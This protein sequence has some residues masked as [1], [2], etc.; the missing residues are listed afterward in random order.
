MQNRK[1]WCPGCG[2]RCSYFPLRPRANRLKCRYVI[3]VCKGPDCLPEIVD[4]IDQQA[5]YEAWKRQPA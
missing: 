2:E 1:V 3:T 4:V 5:Q